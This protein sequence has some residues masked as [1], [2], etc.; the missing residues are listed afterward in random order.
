MVDKVF[1]LAVRYVQPFVFAEN[2]IYIRKITAGDPTDAQ[3]LVIA[4]R[5]KEVWRAAQNIN[6][7]YADWVATQVLGAGVTYSAINCRQ[8]GGTLQTGLLTGT[9]AGANGSDALP[10]QT[11]VTVNV[12][13]ALRGRSYR[14][15]NQ[16]GGFSETNSDANGVILAASVLAL[17]TTLDVFRAFYGSGGS[18][19]DFRWCTFSRGIASGC[20]P[21]PDLR[22][23][24][25][26]HRQAGDVDASIANV[27][28]A[29]VGTVW[30]T[31][32]TR[33]R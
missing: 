33:A 14:T 20:Y 22:H 21:N 7:L 10:P 27:V 19:A 18:D 26:Q 13:T 6:V 32:R 1:Q 4:N 30:T 16:I 25:L 31:M 28:S 24:P 9:L 11:A 15:H 2:V 3:F 8:V 5:W 23:H 29:T 17:Q 12:H